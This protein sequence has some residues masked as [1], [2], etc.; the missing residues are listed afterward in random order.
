[1]L[2]NNIVIMFNAKRITY[3]VSATR[4]WLEHMNDKGLLRGAIERDG[5]YIITLG[6]IERHNLEF[7]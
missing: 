2:Q 6:R 3:A 7:Y 4:V 1:M 5:T